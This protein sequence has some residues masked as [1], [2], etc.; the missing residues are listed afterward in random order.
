LN[1]ALALLSAMYRADSAPSKDKEPTGTDLEYSL[2]IRHRIHEEPKKLLEIV[3]EEVDAHH[4][5]VC[6]IVK[7]AIKAVDGN[8]DQIGQI[9]ETAATTQP[10]AMRLAAQCAVAAVPE[11]LQTVQAVLSK[12]DPA[13]GNLGNGSKDAKDCKDA[14]DSKDA[15][16]PI[17]VGPAITP[18]NPLDL[19]P[20]PPPVPP[21]PPPPP[22]AT[23]TS[24]RHHTE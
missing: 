8:I 18:P 10:E 7:A 20:P 11:S 21:I 6:E 22:P 2:N 23:N 19:P 14:K 17:Q 3:A 5:R 9:V 15:K 4:D 1:F 24:F 16:T 13:S 12:L